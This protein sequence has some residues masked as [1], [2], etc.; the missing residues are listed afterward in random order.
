MLNVLIVHRLIL[1]SLSSFVYYDQGQ[2]GHWAVQSVECSNVS[3]TNCNKEGV[4]LCTIIEDVHRS[5]SNC[6]IPLDP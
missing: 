2:K 3:T 1:T 5:I 4:I 6:L